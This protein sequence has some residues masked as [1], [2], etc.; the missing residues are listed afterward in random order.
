MECGRAQRRHRFSGANRA[1]KAAWRFASRRSP[2]FFADYIALRLGV[3]ALN[4]D[5][6]L[7]AA[8]ETGGSNGG[9]S[10]SML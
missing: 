4:S 5:R 9:Y 7:P 3:F 6:F 2:R 10:A 1:D 8:F